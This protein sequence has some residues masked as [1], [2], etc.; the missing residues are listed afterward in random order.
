MWS[1]LLKVE[2]ILVVILFGLFA[3]TAV[4]VVVAS[5]PGCDADV[6][7][8]VEVNI[9]KKKTIPV[10]DDEALMQCPIV[11]ELEHQ[12]WRLVPYHE[13][14][15][16]L[17]SI[18]EEK[19]ETLEVL[20]CDTQYKI[21]KLQDL[22]ESHQAVMLRVVDQIWQ[23]NRNLHECPL[24]GNA[25]QWAYDYIVMP[26]IWKVQDMVNRWYWQ[27]GGNKVEELIASPWDAVRDFIFRREQLQTARNNLSYLLKAKDCE[28]MLCVIVRAEAIGNISLGLYANH[29]NASDI[30]ASP[31]M[32]VKEWQKIVRQTYTMWVADGKSEAVDDDSPASYLCDFAL[33]AGN[34]FTV[35]IHDHGLT[36][37][38]VE[39]MKCDLRDWSDAI[40]LH[41]SHQSHPFNFRRPHR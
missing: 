37:A 30:G 36:K 4:M 34:G 9:N 38:E 33:N 35:D 13:C 7:F 18:R 41:R 6:D 28:D 14:I 12:R 11:P 2:K 31:R 39:S 20:G 40:L 8:S 26:F 25:L 17:T 21:G 22:P 5:L 24:V 23:L 19:Q 1:K 15:S 32:L 16:K 29:M 27:G 10:P 3:L